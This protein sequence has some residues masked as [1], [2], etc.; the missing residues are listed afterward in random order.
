[1]NQSQKFEGI[2]LIANAKVPIIK[3]IE[4]STQF[5]FDLSFNKMDGLKQI[6]ELQKAFDLYP[7]MKYMIVIIKCILRQRDLH[8][9]Y[10][11]G[12]G[13]FLL[14]QMVLAYLREVRRDLF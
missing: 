10:S 8:E 9:T 4:I 6:T 5:H 7:E 3:F 12:I 2:N 14:F 1:M 11:G 13:S